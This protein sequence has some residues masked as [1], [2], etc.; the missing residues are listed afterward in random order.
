MAFIAEF[1]PKNKAGLALARLETKKY[2]QGKHLVDKYVNKFKELIEQGSYDQG[3]TVVVKFHQGLDKD[4]QDVIA[5][6]PIR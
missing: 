6:I 3:L 2:Y 5:N 4:I 1:C